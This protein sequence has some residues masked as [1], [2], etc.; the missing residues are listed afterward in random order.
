MSS[1]LNGHIY[2]GEYGPREN[3]LSKVV[4]KSI[5]R[6]SNW[7]RIFSEKNIEAKNFNGTHVHR[8]A[9]DPFTN[10]VWIT[11]GDGK[12]NRGIYRS[13]DGGTSW[14]YLIDSQAT[15]IA[16]SSKAIFFGEDKKSGKVSRYIR[17]SKKA[18]QIFNASK[19]GNY[20]GSIYDLLIGRLGTL[21]VPTMKYP[22]QPHIGSVWARIRNEWKLLIELPSH[23]G[24]GIGLETIAGPDVDGWIYIPGYKILDR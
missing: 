1:D 19:N 3:G 17:Q 18:K 4:W 23:E 20:G 9:V 12:K 13:T 24:K 22:D 16:F 7:K 15:G 10:H 14:Q 8:V 2:I 21:Y 6:G 5:D 11:V